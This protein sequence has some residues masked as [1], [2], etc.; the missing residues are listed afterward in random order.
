MGE[1]G[2][3]NRSKHSNVG[4][5]L[6]GRMGVQSRNGAKSRYR[7]FISS[8]K[9]WAMIS[10]HRVI[11]CGMLA[12]SFTQ[13]A[14]DAGRRDM[15]NQLLSKTIMTLSLSDLGNINVRI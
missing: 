14:M 12:L 9:E 1:K 15:L 7:C 2:L 3:R 6:F 13:G 8:I 11:I 4:F 10:I 5:L